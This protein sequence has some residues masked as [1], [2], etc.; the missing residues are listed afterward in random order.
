MRL[1]AA[2]AVALAALVLLTLPAAQADESKWCRD[3]RRKCKENCC[4]GCDVRFSCK[5]DGE[6]WRRH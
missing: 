6:L 2:L 4:K 1:T 5:D 3:Q